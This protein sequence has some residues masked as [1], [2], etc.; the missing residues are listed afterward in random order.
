MK[1]SEASAVSQELAAPPSS[2]IAAVKGPVGVSS[3]GC[4]I[5]GTPKYKTG[6]HRHKQ[7]LPVRSQDNFP[8]LNKG[9]ASHSSLELDPG[10]L[11]PIRVMEVTYMGKMDRHE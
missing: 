10:A 4:V 5:H 3:V 1:L 2:G 9:R 6:T 11:V 8:T 7:K